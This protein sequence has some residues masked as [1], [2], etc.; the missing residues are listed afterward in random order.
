[1]RSPDTELAE[2]HLEL[3]LPGLDRPWAR[4][5]R[6]APAR[7]L[8]A[9]PRDPEAVLAGAAALLAATGDLAGAAMLGR[10]RLTAAPVPSAG[11]P[12]TRVVVQ[13]SPEDRARTWRD[14]G[15]DDRIRRAVRDATLRA[16]ERVVVELGVNLHR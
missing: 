1:M 9:E 7:D 5:Y 3:V 10:A 15:L 8:P 11:T 12:L 14:P 6:E 2:L 13:L 4:V 16:A